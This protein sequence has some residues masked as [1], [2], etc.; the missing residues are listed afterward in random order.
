MSSEGK[1]TISPSAPRLCHT[2]PD[3]SRA[4][5]EHPGVGYRG[6]QALGCS[7]HLGQGIVEAAQTDIAPAMW[8]YEKYLA[9]KG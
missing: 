2:H 8:E 6:L 1:C 9:L 4:L 3:R 7:R 5:L